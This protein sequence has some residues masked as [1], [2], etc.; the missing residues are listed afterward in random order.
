L[1]A[2]LAA[3]LF[4]TVVVVLPVVV[5]PGVAAGDPLPLGL[6]TCTPS[7]SDDETP[8]TFVGGNLRMS[9]GVSEVGGRWIVMGDYSVPQGFKNIGNALGSTTS[10]SNNVPVLQVGGNVDLQGQRVDVNKGG[11]PR[12]AGTINGSFGSKPGVR[13]PNA[14][15][16]FTSWSDTIK[17]ASAEYAKATPTGTV[18]GNVFRGTNNPTLELFTVTSGTFGNPQFQ[19]ISPSATVVVNIVGSSPGSPFDYVSLS[20]TGKMGLQN[21]AN[22]LW[23]F[24]SAAA[25][26]LSG[27]NTGSEIWGS[28]LVGDVPSVTMSSS[29]INWNGRLIVAGDLNIN[30]PRG[31]GFEIHSACFTGTGLPPAAPVTNGQFTLEKVVGSGNVLVDTTFTVQVDC[32]AGKPGTGPQTLTVAA[33]TASASVD[34]T[35]IPDKT[36]CTVSEPPAQLPAGYGLTSIAYPGGSGATSVTIDATNSNQKV[37]VTNSLK[38]GNLKVTKTVDVADPSGPQQF[39]VNVDCGGVA[40]VDG[41]HQITVPASGLSATQTFQGIPEG[42]ACTVTEPNPGSSY[43]TPTITGSPATILA[44]TNPSTAT[45]TVANRRLLGHIDI[46]KAATGAPVPAGGATFSAHID[47]P[48]TTW[49]SDVALQLPNSGPVRTS[50]IPVGMVCQVNEDTS[51]LPPGWALDGP[52]GSTDVTVDEDPGAEITFTNDYTTS[53]IRLVKNVVSNGAPVNLLQDTDFTF[54]LDCDGTAFDGN[55]FVV[56]RAGQSSGSTT[57]GGLPVGMHCTADEP[58]P[59]PAGFSKATNFRTPTNG[60]TVVAGGTVDIA[61]A[62]E[63]VPFESFDIVKNLTDAHPSL[64]GGGSFEFS[65]RCANP[66]FDRSPTIVIPNGQTTGRVTVPRIPHGMTCDVSEVQSNPPGK[67]V[68]VSAGPQRVTVATGASVSFTNVR[69]DGQVT[70]RKDITGDTPPG[71]VSFTINLDCGG[72][73]TTFDSA[74][75]VTV[76]P[77]ATS[78]TTVVAGLP[79][80]LTCKL[81]ESP[82]PAGWTRGTVDPA[83]VTVPGAGQPAVTVTATNDYQT[84]TVRL[85]K[86]VVQGGAPATAGADTTFGLVL[87]CSVNAFDRTVQVTVPA[88]ASTAS[89]S[90]AGVPVGTTCTVTEPT[91]PAGFRLTTPAAGQVTVGDGTTVDLTVT[92][93]KIPYG[94]FTITK[95]LTGSFLDGAATFTFTVDCTDD[96]YDQSVPIVTSGASASATVT[97]GPIEQGVTCTVTEDPPGPGPWA[98]GPVAGSPVTVSAT[99]QAVTATNSRNVGQVTITKVVTGATPP[100]PVDF[101]IGL[102][103][104]GTAFD[105]TQTL[106][107]TPPAT[108]ASVVV[109]NLPVGLSCTASERTP[110]PPGW[111][112]APLSPSTFTV[113]GAGA[114]AVTVTATND[115]ATGTVRLVKST[116]SGGSPLAVAADTAF[117]LVLDCDGTT[118]D[119]TRTLTVGSGTSS[120]DVLVADIPA[121]TQCSVSEHTQPRGWRLTTPPAGQVTVGDGTTVDLTVTDAKIPDGSFTITKALTGTVL[122]APATFTFDVDCNDDFYD[123]TVP[124]STN[125]IATSASVTVGPIQQGV[126]CSVAEQ[127]PGPGPWSPVSVTPGSVTVGATAQVVTATN[128]RVLGQ[129]TLRKDITGDTPPAPVSFV[130]R[131]DCSGTAH[132]ADHTVTVTPPATSGSVIVGSLPVGLDC[133]ATEAAPP[134]GWTRTSPASSSFTVPGAGEAAV[135][136]TAVNDYETGTIT[137]RKETVAGTTPVDVVLDTA[138][139]LRVDCDGTAFD[140]DRTI[141]VAAGTS[142]QSLDVPGIPAGST[143]SVTEPTQPRGWR[144]LSPPPAPV[145]VTATG[146]PFVM[147]VVDQQIPTGTF[148]IT[149]Q[150]SGS[151]L[152]APASFTFDVACDDASFDQTVVVATSGFS[153]SASVTVGPVFQGV[154]CTVTEQPPG[155]GPWSPGPVT[156]SPVTV[157][158]TNQVV[159]ATNS[160]NLGQ[161]TLRKDI[162]GDTPPRPVSFTMVLDCTGKGF[163]GKYPI[164]VTPPATS[165]SVV[166]SDLPVGL[167]CSARE[168]GVP[169]GWSAVALD[170]ATFEVPPTGAPAVTVVA[171]NDYRTGDVQV[172]KNTVGAGGVAQPVS[173]DTD[174]GMQLDCTGT[175]D[176][177]A[178]T[179][180]VDDGASTGST[181]VTGIPS[182]STCS[183]KEP[184]PLPLLWS[185]RS[186]LPASVT[187]TDGGTAVLTVTNSAVPTGQFSIEKTL[188][189]A[190]EDGA[191][192]LQFTVDCDDDNFDRTVTLPVRDGD[193][194]ASVTVGG[195]PVG[196]VCDVSEADPGPKWAFTAL[197][198]SQV[199]IPDPADPAVSVAVT[200]TRLTGEV[201]LT[202]QVTGDLQVAAATFTIDLDCTGTAFDSSHDLTVTPP[203]TSESL[204]VTGLPV[205]LQCSASES[206]SPPGWTPVPFSPATFTVPG[207]G[208]AGVT[209]TAV[210][211]LTTGS[212]TL[213]KSTSEAVPADTDFALTLDCDGGDFD[214]TEVVTVTAGQTTGS[215]AV[216]NLPVGVVCNVTEP[217]PPL[218]WSLDSVSPA[219]V[220]VAAGP[221]QVV[222]VANVPDLGDFTITKVLTGAIEDGAGT[223]TFRLDCTNDLY[224]R[225]VDLTVASGQ[226]TAS[227]QVPA[228]PKGTVCDIT[229]VDPGPRWSEVS[230]SPAA[231]TVGVDATVTA[232]N[233]RQSGQVTLTKQVVGDFQ[234][235]PATFTLGLDCTGTTWDATYDLTVTPP[236]SA[237]S[238]T[239]TGLPVGL[240]CTATEQGAP[241]GWSKVSPTPASFTVPGTGQAAV[242]VTAVNSLTTGS[243]TLTKSTSEAVPADTDFALTLDCDGGDFDSTE[244]VTVASGQTTGS[245]TVDNLP[246]GVVCRVTEPSPPV[247]WAFGGV[248]PAQVTVASGPARVVTVSNVPDLGTFTIAKALTGPLEDGAATFTFT[249]DCTNDLYDQDVT[250]PMSAAQAT[251]SVQVPGIPVG[252]VCDITEADPGPAWRQVSVTPSTVTVGTDTTVDV[253]N[254]RQLGQVTLTKVATG[255]FQVVPATF[256]LTLDCTGT[257]WDGSHDLTVTPP[258]TAD[259]VVV[260]DLPVGLRC[261]VVEQTPPK[262]WTPVTPVPASFTVPGTGQAA[263]TVTATNELVTGSVTLTKS[264]SEAVPADTDFALTLDCD[265][266][267][268]D[269]TE[270]VTVAAG[271]TTGSLTVDNLPVGVVCNVTEPSPPTGWTLD[272]I[273]PAQVTVASGPAQVVTVSNVPD[274]GEFR[275]TKTL[276]GPLEDGGDGF[277]FEVDCTNDLYDDLTDV[278]VNDGDSSGSTVVS[279]IPVGTVCDVTELDSGPYWQEVSVT[280][281]SVVV[282][283]DPEVTVENSRRTGEITLTKQVTGD[284]SPQDTTFTFVLDCTGTTWDGPRNLTVP[285]GS[286]T[287][288]LVVSN[289]PAG[290]RC[291]L[292]ESTP[293]VGWSN[294]DLSPASVEVPG[295][296]QAAVTVTAVNDYETGSVTVTKDLTVNSVGSPVFKMLLD[297]DG[298]FFD[299]EVTVRVDGAIGTASVTVDDLPAG[300]VCTVTEKKTSFW[301]L[302]GISPS[303]VTV[304]D[305]TAEELTVTNEPFNRGEIRVVKQLSGYSADGPFTFSIDVDCA[306][307]TFDRVIDLT[308]PA[309]GTSAEYTLGWVPAGTQCSLAEVDPGPN[310]AWSATAQSVTVANGVTSDAT[311]TNTRRE[312]QVTITKKAA[313]ASATSSGDSTFKVRLYCDAG[314]KRLVTLDIPAGAD[315]SNTE[316]VTLPSGLNCT[317]VQETAAFNGWD[318]SPTITGDAPFTVPPPGPPHEV[319]LENQYH[320]GTLRLTKELTRPSTLDQDFELALDCDGFAH[321]QDVTLSIAKGQT[322]ASIDVTGLPAL[323]WPSPG[324]PATKGSCNVS[325]IVRDGW[326]LDS[327]TVSSSLQGPGYLATAPLKDGGATD[328]A[329]TNEQLPGTVVI[330]KVVATSGGT[331][332]TVF[333]FDLSCEGVAPSTVELTLPTGSM[334]GQV[335]VPDMPGGS[336]CTVAEVDL[337]EH[338]VE[339][340]T[341]QPAG[342]VLGNGNPIT[343]TVT[344]DRPVGRLRFTKSLV[345]P[346]GVD[347]TFAFESTCSDPAWSS[348][349]G[350]SV[351]AGEAAAEGF[352]SEVP[353]DV[354]CTLAEQPIDGWTLVSAED[355]TV[356]PGSG[357]AAFTNRFVAPP[358]TPDDGGVA[359]AGTPLAGTGADPGMLVLLGMLLVAGGVILH[360]HDRRR[361]R[362]T[363][364]PA[365]HG[366]RPGPR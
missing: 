159:T 312:G 329:Y 170:P 62:N 155:P 306:G 146:G 207:A 253:V 13:D 290:L 81:T 308:V 247:G 108:S 343:A 153:D 277:I 314:T 235:A 35:G 130:V 225:D 297:C 166:V 9:G 202:K 356:S 310:W 56:V 231:V 26:S 117:D 109:G 178:V 99:V 182:G 195:I 250:L 105:S 276:T 137:L 65:V 80:G 186:A 42:R 34:V 148:T 328:V 38:S 30:A 54:R 307:T 221:A 180:T 69:Q 262:G 61:L 337:P 36:V 86:N 252:T 244:I 214:A 239:V 324:L 33:G 68:P 192:D 59:L 167:R 309:G 365:A 353:A 176:D 124:V 181:T 287:A 177:Q 131:F 243:V 318:P 321:D 187:V 301:N 232:T 330:D 303:S 317:R 358:G 261:N 114:P 320:P 121:G 95:Q 272:R 245:L 268:F 251:G 147:T 294:V 285:K 20:A 157:G 14:V 161:I 327:I 183:V 119:G 97:V 71:P 238:V 123:Q 102:D 357:A 116:V 79:V 58:P 29:I 198:P 92:D 179:V 230:I 283:T 289:L 144:L 15:A 75:T 267:D 52:V 270:I 5:A 218:G 60:Q 31:G 171:T 145:V 255:A 77:P 19:N 90:V 72:T 366:G 279:G 12:Y 135:T 185:F 359:G 315:T 254:D 7:A 217:S 173:G 188:A 201:T 21:P 208:A 133:T 345:A 302:V 316:S 175:A 55:H 304:G 1:S 115:Y 172:V 134:L 132:D 275:I 111:T 346:V 141:T 120:A 242:T 204:V 18:T 41:D 241:V 164:T 78:G 88:S 151:F 344:N 266:G 25:V 212:V 101:G 205:G 227:V 203:A 229:E 282:G 361:D 160:R 47:C 360:R 278:Y 48:G 125:G 226:A 103:C 190:N 325:E 139:T 152:D 215:V 10:P 339:I 349:L 98:Q 73:D 213:A 248:S 333:R 271:G 28:L 66:F 295:Q 246:V 362:M 199:T 113:P 174:F 220:T 274:P 249:L 348:V 27:P 50:A 163:D 264:T 292:T 263:V 364:H 87:D 100:G 311:F 350:L 259:S 45:V 260:T 142:Q 236:S 143:C 265:G 126:T 82:P 273:D 150:L 354:T 342:R 286:P 347:G 127:P 46:A 94:S 3:L 219:Q 74:R 280:P 313:P 89:Q 84:G 209:V 336:L 319:V 140:G 293:P 296:G 2:S 39:T 106:T 341:V 216:D 16:A 269:A 340:S 228:V 256:T 323:V 129:V 51:V 335:V 11:A 118:W 169:L 237:D 32:G 4:S 128:A 223:F 104:T 200:D 37:T 17:T 23:N 162:T 197:S 57:V 158:G 196:T 240:R 284:P 258:A 91:Q 112:A 6:G 222:T 363:S 154:T 136:V 184:P 191:V 44:L 22:L 40:G 210:N 298:D 43:G 67:W 63:Q 53:S 291:D 70:L 189:G 211:S 107:I 281:P 305:G 233:S 194:T 332:P 322:T 85:V 299:Q 288:S 355:T 122:D 156:G 83:S 93:A 352:R 224:D 64:D 168:S 334:S 351:F 8:Q 110:L 49:D 338:W 331:E 257:T 76:T 300:S 326:A 96:A 206:A 149:K 165:A 24:P 138:F 193:A 234:V